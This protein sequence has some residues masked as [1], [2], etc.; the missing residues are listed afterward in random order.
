MTSSPPVV[1]I[2]EDEPVLRSCMVR[3][4]VKDAAIQV[5]DAA[6]VAEAR[7]LI[8]ALRPSFIISDLDLPDGTGLEVIDLVDRLGLRAPILFA[9]AYVPRYRPQIPSR[10]G[11][12]VREKPIPLSELR[13]AV[14]RSLSLG[15]GDESDAAEP[16]S[17]PDYVQLACMCRRSVEIRL[18]H[19]DVVIG[20]IVI[21]D[22]ELVHAERGAAVGEEAAYSLVY[23]GTLAARCYP[24]RAPIA[25]SITLGW[26]GVLLEAARRHDEAERDRSTPAT[27]PAHAR[28]YAEGLADVPVAPAKSTAPTSVTPPR[29][30]LPRPPPPPAPPPRAP[31]SLPPRPPWLRASGPGLGARP[32]QPSRRPELGAL[33]PVRAGYGAAECVDRAA[34]EA[35]ERL[36]D[37]AVA[38]LLVKD[39]PSALRCFLAADAA[40][41]GDSRARAN[42]QRLR[43]L[44]VSEP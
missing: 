42:L 17:A 7:R 37:D 32:D 15:P 39:Y 43:A 29:A 5:V 24:L 9:S 38:A 3:G 44:G 34:R 20:R 25:P 19:D 27:P 18:Q 33:P 41:A 31:A 1:L 12:E 16:F 6:S 11:V 23:D 28:G 36:Y 30:Q 21:S 8:E 22:G 35:F 26:Q 14:A 10:A 13:A 2:I 40:V 4:L